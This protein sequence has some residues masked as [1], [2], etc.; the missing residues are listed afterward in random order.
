VGNRT[1]SITDLV[2]VG[3]ISMRGR[4]VFELIYIYG[5]YP[6]TETKKERSVLG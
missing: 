1:W 3:Q 2:Y 4:L 6:P 5:I